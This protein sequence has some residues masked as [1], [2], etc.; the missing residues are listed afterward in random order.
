MTAGLVLAFL[1]YMLVYAAV[2]NEH[3]WASVVRAFGGQPPPP[4]GSTN[5]APGHSQAPG[6]AGVVQAP[7]FLTPPAQKALAAITDTYPDLAYQGGFNC[8]RIIPHDGGTSDEWSE[9]AWGNALDFTGPAVLMR[10]LVA[11]ANVPHIKLRYKIANVIPPGS[12]VNSV[13]ID[14]V[15]SHT[16]Q[17]PPCAS[18]GSR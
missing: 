6:G 4:P 17:T 13:H 10:K 11:W 1:G 5:E 2:K 3:P 9:H 8:R 7:G 18:A 15:P 12:A 16:G 14:F